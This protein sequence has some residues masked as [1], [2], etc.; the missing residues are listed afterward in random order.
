MEEFT[1]LL[2]NA[3]LINENFGNREVGPLWNLSIMTNK[4][5]VNNEKHLNMNLVEFYEAIARVADRFDMANLKDFFE[6]YP[7]K[8]PWQLDKKIESTFCL[9]IRENLTPKVFKTQLA[10]YGEAIHEEM[11]E[12][13]R[14]AVASFKR[15]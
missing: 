12:E 13:A 5:E 10:R 14:G 1:S 2:S 3:G 4:D 6:E 8:S 11:E 7:G 15:D 9:L